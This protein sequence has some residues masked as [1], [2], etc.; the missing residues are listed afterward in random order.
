MTL[1]AR[2]D[3]QVSNA[4]PVDDRG[5]QFGDGVFETIAIYRGQPLL[6]DAHLARMADGCRRLGFEPPPPGPVERDL[7]GLCAGSERA[8]AKLI[9]TRGSGPRGYRAGADIRPRTVLTLHDWSRCGVQRRTGLVAGICRLRLGRQPQLA[10]IK[11][12]NRL[13]QVLARAQWGRDWQEGLLLDE[14][15]RVVS[16]TQSNIFFLLDNSL[17][18]PPV[19]DNGIAGIMRATVIRCARDLEIPCREHVV[20]ADELPVI[21]QAF[22]TN[23]IMGVAPVRQLDGRA[24]DIGPEIRRLQT[25]LDEKNFVV[26]D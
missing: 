5:L 25:C 2:V 22:M 16:G 1:R 14:Q 23:C 15:D 20:T 21:K 3:G 13:E 8:I 9:V 4:I 6:L 24:L 17:I 12:L 7:A 18:T 10:G 11:H 19:R 26:P